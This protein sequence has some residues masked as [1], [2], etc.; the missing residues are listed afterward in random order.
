MQPGQAAARPLRQGGQRNGHLRAG[1]AR[2]GRKPT[3][4]SRP[5]WTPPRTCPG[6]WSPT[7]QFG[8]QDGK[9]PWYR[10]ADTVLYEIHVKGFTMRHPDIPPP[11]RGTYAG[12]GHEAAIAYLKDLGVTTVEL[13]PGTPERARGVPHRAGAD[14]LLGLQ[15]HRLLRP[16]QRLLRRRPGRPPGRPGRRVPGDGGRAAPGRPGS[17]PRRGVQPHRRSRPRRPHAVLPRHRQ[18]GLLPGRS[19]RPRRCTT[20]P[21]AAATR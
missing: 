18:P 21:P 4:P 10:Y 9:R 11:L 8:W 5:P 12:L 15:H 1:G 3:P 20:T 13:L 6:A 17:D 19:R 7:R 14:E 2:P 16:A